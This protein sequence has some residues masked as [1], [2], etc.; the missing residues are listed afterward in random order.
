M[1]DINAMQVT[2]TCKIQNIPNE[3]DAGSDFAFCIEVAAEPKTD[4]VGQVLEIIDHKKEILVRPQLVAKNE[5][6]ESHTTGAIMMTAPA[7]AGLYKWSVRIAPSETEEVSFL[8]AEAEIAVR[9]VAHRLA[10]V[11]WDVPSAISPGQA[12]QVKIGGRCSSVCNASGWTISVRNH[13]G[14]TIART[15]TG[16]TPWPGTSGLRYAELDLVAPDDVGLFNWEVSF[17]APESGLP[18]ETGQRSFGVRTSP[19]ADARLRIEAVDSESGAPVENLKVIV[20]PFS[21]RTGP[22]GTAEIAVP[23]GAHRVFVSGKGYIPNRNECTVDDTQTIRVELE[24]DR[25]LSEA[26]VWG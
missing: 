12:F 22:D 8:A 19:P 9:A 13:E 6:S 4:L 20:H 21:A 7:R 5:E 11:V 1:N 2:R 18:H 15:Q 14:R 24:P 26:E 16:E 10:P 23:N 17:E 3:I 25:G